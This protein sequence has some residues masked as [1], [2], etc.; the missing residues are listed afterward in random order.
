L[1]VRPKLC[2]GDRFLD[3]SGWGKTAGG[4]ENSVEVPGEVKQSESRLKKGRGKITLQDV[5]I[6]ES[7]KKVQHVA[8]G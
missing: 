6:N 4:E 7:K 8:A 3:N 2:D 5:A 1:I